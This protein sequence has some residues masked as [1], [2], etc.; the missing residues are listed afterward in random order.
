MFLAE[1]SWA[2][3]ILCKSYTALNY[4]DKAR[5]IR[6]LVIEAARQSYEWD[7]DNHDIKSWYV[8]AL[9]EAYNSCFT[10]DFKGTDPKLRGNAD[11]L[12]QQSAYLDEAIGVQEELYNENPAKHSAI[13]AFLDCEK[14]IE[15]RNVTRSRND[16]TQFEKIEAEYV[17]ALETYGV[18][19]EHNPRSYAHFVSDAYLN[20][21]A[22]YFDYGKFDE[23]D[24]VIDLFL[25]AKKYEEEELEYN[26]KATRRNHAY[27]LWALGFTYFR[28]GDYAN[29]EL[30][31][32]ESAEE[33]KPLYS[34]SP[35]TIW[36][37]YD[38]V[39]YR[40]YELYGREAM[41]DETKL[42]ETRKMLD[43]LEADYRSFK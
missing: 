16:S 24:K 13:L 34:E 36:S 11:I 7:K 18:A 22:L 3:T 43:H 40:L 10:L 28:C 14:A 19:Y 8:D 21:G 17:K 6:P 38:N 23:K 15:I 41:N 39:Y 33:L 2:L 25:N 30:C 32:L 42:D 9:Y 4:A 27:I 26:P 35:M 1:R 29:A 37:I 31:Y 20:Y 12:E 5:H